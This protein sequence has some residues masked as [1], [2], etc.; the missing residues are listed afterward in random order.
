MKGGF[1]KGGLASPTKGKKQFL[2]FEEKI[3][4]QNKSLLYIFQ[5]SRGGSAY[6]QSCGAHRGMRMVK[7]YCGTLF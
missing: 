7:K 3:Q 4:Q 5:I 1:R 6:Q 2:K